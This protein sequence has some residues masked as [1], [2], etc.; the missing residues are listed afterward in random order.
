MRSENIVQGISYI[1]IIVSLAVAFG[2]IFDITLLKSIMPDYPPMKLVTS[3]S[4]FLAGFITLL[5]QSNKARRN[6]VKILFLCILSL[7]LLLI[8]LI[9]L[10]NTLYDVQNLQGNAI[11]NLSNEGI[12]D[13]IY[14]FL[15]RPSMISMLSFILITLVVLSNIFNLKNSEKYQIIIGII[16]SFLGIIAI[17]GYIFNIPGLF[18]YY[19]QLNS[20]MP[21]HSAIL[22]VFIGIGI[23]LIGK[24]KSYYE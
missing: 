5:L 19:G 13:N 12:N 2:W 11:N 15:S 17:L 14:T 9:Y 4:F 7:L 24:D 8:M 21:L 1:T 22:F 3:S 10:Y 6:K 16:I 20:G 23:Y 18:Y